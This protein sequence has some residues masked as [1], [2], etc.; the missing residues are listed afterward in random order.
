MSLNFC[1]APDSLE[2]QITFTKEIGNQKQWAGGHPR[3]LLHFFRANG[4]VQASSID[5]LI[6]FDH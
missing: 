5:L 4:T 2:L 3:W 6:T 1:S